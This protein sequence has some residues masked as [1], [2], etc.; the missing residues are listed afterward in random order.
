MILKLTTRYVVKAIQTQTVK[1]LFATQ[2][3]VWLPEICTPGDD[4]F[5][6]VKQ[7]NKAKKNR[8]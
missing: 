3:T 6:L 4:K 7:R 8:W 2:V 1:M 5:Q